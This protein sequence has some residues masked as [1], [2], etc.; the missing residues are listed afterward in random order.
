MR[1]AMVP[2]PAAAGAG[3]PHGVG[4]GELAEELRRLGDEV[5]SVSPRDSVEVVRRRWQAHRPDVVHADGVAAGRLALQA[6]QGLAVPVAVALPARPALRRG[7]GELAACDAAGAPGAILPVERFLVACTTD[8]FALR[9]RGVEAARLAVVPAAVDLERFSPSRPAEAPAL[10]RRVLVAAGSSP[11]GLA[12][13]LVALCDLPSAELV[14]VPSGDVRS[15]ARDPHLEL[16]AR[17]LGLAGRVSWRPQRA[18]Q[19]WPGVLRSADVVVVL[20]VPRRLP[21]VVLEA[22]ACGLPV[23]ATAGGVHLDLV[24]H[25]R[26][27]VLV[28]AGDAAG[29]VSALRLLLADPG[30]RWAMARAGLERARQHSLEQVARRVRAALAAART[31]RAARL[32]Q[33]PVGVLEP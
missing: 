28:E 32:R 13:L 16:M 1:V 31:G 18:E 14:V 22:M 15:A 25:G 19:D 12:D 29:L 26:S 5:W 20:G 7:R 3:R 33:R 2:A 6:A 23:V 8:A 27:G 11:A 30:L 10:P 17:A 4:A 9:R 24:V 21:G